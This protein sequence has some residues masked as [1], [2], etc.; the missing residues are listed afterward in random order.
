MPQ[1]KK[2]PAENLEKWNNDM[3]LKHP[4]PY[5]GLAGYV[6]K[7]RA[8]EI[9]KEIR[10]RMTTDT[11]TLLE[12]GCEAGK[13]LSILR[14]S[15]PSAKFHG[16]DISTEALAEA[17]KNLGEGVTLAHTD[18]AASE[19]SISIDGLDFIVCS[20]TLEHIPDIDKAV[21]NLKQI[22]T[23][24]QFVI[25]TVPYEKIKNQI[26]KILNKLR[27]FDFLLTGIEKEFSEW[28]VNNFSKE[29]LIHMFEG[30]FEIIQYKKILALHQMLVMRKKGE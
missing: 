24:N 30:Q 19:I 6:E 20:E 23:S 21:E 5:G 18:L 16:H 14:D 27:V 10:K 11:F 22:A 25:I 15:F 8:R 3:F 7:T 2:Q 17:K 4:T 1:E 29:D 12:I 26:K 9:V 28:H 13:L